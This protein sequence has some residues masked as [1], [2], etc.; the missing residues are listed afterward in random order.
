MKSSYVI[1]ILMA[2]M[3]LNIGCVS[4][5]TKKNWEQAQ[6]SKAV[7]VEADG[8][9][10]LM[11]VDLTSGSYLKDNWGPAIAA[12]IAD[13]FLVYGAWWGVN[14]VMDAVD[15]TG[16]GDGNRTGEGDAGNQDND[17][18]NINITINQ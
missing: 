4:M 2:C 17:S 12:G 6:K 1:T 5:W 16:G 13:A 7:R 11:G 3:F 14:E 18:N 8:D 10:V 15:D 9:T